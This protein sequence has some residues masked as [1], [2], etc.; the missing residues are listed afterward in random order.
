MDFQVDF[1]NLMEDPVPEEAARTR[2]RQETLKPYN[3]ETGPLL[4]VSLMKLAS[5]RHVLFLGM[6]HIVSDGVSLGVLTREFIELY[7]SIHKGEP[8]ALPALRIQYRDFA[9]W[10]NRLLESPAVSVHRNYWHEKLSGKSPGS[11]P[12]DGFSPARRSNLPR[13]GTGF[14]SESGAD[15]DAGGFQPPA[16]RDPV[17]D[18]GRN[19]QGAALPIHRVSDII[20]GS[21]IAGRNHAD[22]E[23]QIGLYLNTLALR[24]QFHEDI[25]FELLLHQV[26][27]TATEAYDHQIYPFDRLVGDLGLSRNLSRSPL[28]DV[29]V[30]LQNTEIPDLSLENVQTRA[31]FQE[32][33]IS[34]FDL[35]FEFEETRDGL[36]V[37]IEYNTDL[38]GKIEFKESPDISVSWWTAFCLMP[39]APL[40]G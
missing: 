24:D 19:A 11:E 21:P 2:I 32:S 39:V 27:Q 5:R 8:V 36:Q 20:V 16:G 37:G 3:L 15:P 33:R 14:H 1:T 7:Q 40:P 18:A 28:F 35:T 6:H 26:K 13:Q 9:R 22:L 23:N 4:R 34:K 12:A 10:Q 29:M 25:S 31:F 30:I 38:F 17:H